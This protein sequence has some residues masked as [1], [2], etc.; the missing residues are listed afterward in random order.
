MAE[1][2]QKLRYDTILYCPLCRGE[3]MK[4]PYRIDPKLMFEYLE[5]PDCQEVIVG[6]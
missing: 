3:I 6:Q 5:C 4:L 1:T 2:N